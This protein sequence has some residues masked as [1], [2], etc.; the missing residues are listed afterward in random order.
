MF[1][2]AITQSPMCNARCVYAFWALFRTIFCDLFRNEEFRA[3]IEVLEIFQNV[4]K[5]RGLD[6]EPYGPSL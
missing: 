3:T 6:E 4:A 2:R 1:A 5:L